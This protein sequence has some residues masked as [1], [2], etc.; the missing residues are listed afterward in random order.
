MRPTFN[1][2]SASDVNSTLDQL[3]SLVSEDDYPIDG[4]I[5][6][7]AVMLVIPPRARH[8][9][10]PWLHIEVLEHTTNSPLAS[11]QGRFAPN[12]SVWTGF[13]LT[14]IALITLIF[15]AA[16]FGFAQL[17]MHNPP[18]AFG[19]IPA[20]LIAGA[21]MYWS[22]LVGQRLANSQM[23]E[24]YDAVASVVAAQSPAD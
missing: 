5:A 21:I 22:S 3:R 19:L 11:I 18:W 12:P 6:G 1:L 9:W 10:S 4:R 2:T 24:L 8:F 23:H 17:I 16:I 13:M 15:F 7:N 20:L 14:Y